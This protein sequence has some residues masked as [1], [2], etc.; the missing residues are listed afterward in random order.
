MNCQSGALLFDQYKNTLL[1]IAFG[2]YGELKAN[3]KKCNI[4]TESGTN[5]YAYLSLRYCLLKKIQGRNSTKLCLVIKEH[6][7][8]MIDQIFLPP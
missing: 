5:V 7:S 3:G 2:A 6:V 1:K 8:K 4:N